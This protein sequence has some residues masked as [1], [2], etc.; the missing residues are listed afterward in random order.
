MSKDMFNS[1]QQDTLP[2]YSHHLPHSP[3]LDFVPACG[4]F[5]APTSMASSVAISAPNRDNQAKNS[6]VAYCHRQILAITTSGCPRGPGCMLA[7]ERCDRLL[8]WPKSLLAGGS[9]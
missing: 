6:I 1:T 2:C 7:G 5:E 4:I 8:F 9:A 3:A